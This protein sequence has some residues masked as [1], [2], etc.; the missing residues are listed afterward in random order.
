MGIGLL[1]VQEKKNNK[2]THQ[3]RFVQA[4]KSAI[5]QEQKGEKGKGKCMIEIKNYISSNSR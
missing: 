4:G 3:V 1:L 2:N 5:P